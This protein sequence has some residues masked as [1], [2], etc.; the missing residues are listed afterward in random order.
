MAQLFYD[1]FLFSFFSLYFIWN[2][3]YMWLG[4]ARMLIAYSNSRFGRDRSSRCTWMN[5]SAKPFLFISDCVKCIQRFFLSYCFVCSTGFSTFY[6]PFFLFNRR[7]YK[8]RPPHLNPNEIEH[9]CEY[10]LCLTILLF[11]H[12]N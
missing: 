3:Y 7:T 12:S 6:S 4:I 2:P 5:V 8:L 10:G 1:I 9:Q 11:S